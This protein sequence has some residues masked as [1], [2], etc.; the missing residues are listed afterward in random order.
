M[1]IIQRIMEKHINMEKA[2]YNMILPTGATER[3]KSNNIYDLGG[4]VREFTDGWVRDRGYYS[5]GGHYDNIGSHIY[6]LSLIGVE[7]SEKLGYRI[8]LYIK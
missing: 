8:V 3:N 1:D 4:N 2:K 7:P 6:T 5:A